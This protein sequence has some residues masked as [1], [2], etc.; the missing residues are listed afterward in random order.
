MVA[1]EDFARTAQKVNAKAK[2]I[3]SEGDYDEEWGA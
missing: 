1:E 3:G 2:E